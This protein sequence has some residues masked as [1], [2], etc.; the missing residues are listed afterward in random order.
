MFTSTSRL[1]ILK[2]MKSVRPGTTG[3]APSER[4]KS[5]RLLLPKGGKFHVNLSYHPHLHLLLAGHWDGFKIRQ[6][7]VEIGPH[8]LAAHAFSCTEAI[9]EP[10]LPAVQHPIGIAGVSS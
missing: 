10:L 2:I 1:K 9:D 5:S 7:S 3:S 4:R 6:N 8:L